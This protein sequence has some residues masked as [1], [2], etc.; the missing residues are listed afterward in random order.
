[1][2]G[3][4]LRARKAAARLGIAPT[5]QKNRALWEMAAHLKKDA[6]KIAAANKK[7][8]DAARKKGMKP[9]LI[10]RLALDKARIEKI[11]SELEE[12]IALNDPVSETLEEWK[13]K[14]GLL[15]RKVRV[16][17]GVVGIVFESRPNITVDASA[18]CLKSGNAVILRGGSD[19]IN[20]NIAIADS[21]RAALEKAGLPKDCIQAIHS[22]DRGLVGE[23]LRAHGLIDLIIPRG[24]SSLISFVVQNAT[25]PVIETGAGN[26]H[27][28]VDESADLEKAVAIVVNAKCQRPGTCNA[29]ETLLVHEKVSE[30]FLPLAAKALQENKVELRADKRAKEIL[31]KSNFKG[32]KAATGDDWKTEFLDLIL[33]VKTVK[34]IEEAISHINRH[35]TM[36]S[37]AILSQNKESIEKFM[38]QVDAA[39][40]YSNASTRFTDGNQFGLGMEIGISNQKLHARGP[41]GLCE[42]CSYKYMIAGNGQVRKLKSDFKHFLERE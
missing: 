8:L 13:Q 11:A 38:R 24:G 34:N 40:V 33:A 28:F 23:M 19:A 25:V 6:G 35:G 27:C 42:L 22:T 21:L 36:H 17:F 7:D 1:M 20:S 18:L 4:A 2:Q 5:G 30:K 26:C 3:I 37:E 10:D 39:C 31:E 15:I 16:P 14:D 29:I 9:A 41:M 12:V 32:V